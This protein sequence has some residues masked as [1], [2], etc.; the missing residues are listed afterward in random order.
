MEAT[1][2]FATNPTLLTAFWS[3]ATIFFYLVSKAIYRRWPQSWLSPLIVTPLALIALALLLRAN[4][5]EYIH[6]THWLVAMLGPVT[7]AFAI[8]IFEERHT[9][10]RYWP[11]LA[12]GVI[13]GSTTAMLTAWALASLLSI[14]GALRL[15]LLPR[16]ISTPFAMTISQDI[17]GVPDLTAIFVVITGVCGAALGETLLRFLPIRSTLARGA[18]F[19]M[20]AHGAGV[21]K[22]HQIG[23]EEGSIAG[24]VMVL[25]GLVNVLAAPLISMLLR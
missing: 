23:P 3:A 17:G 25:V 20:G 4:Y 1:V 21:A 19:G 22:A 12:F 15:S 24:L 11:V 14:D 16:S 10:R 6:A 13:V 18:L 7:V 8:P 2:P 5:A 9:I